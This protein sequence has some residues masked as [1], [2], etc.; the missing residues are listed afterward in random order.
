MIVLTAYYLLPCVVF[1]CPWF[2]TSNDALPELPRNNNGLAD[3]LFQALLAS[4]RIAVYRRYGDR[5][6]TLQHVSK[7]QVECSCA[8]LGFLFLQ[9]LGHI[10]SFKDRLTSPCGHV[11]RLSRD[12]H[13][14]SRLASCDCVMFLSLQSCQVI[15][16]EH[17]FR[18]N[19]SG[20]QPMMGGNAGSSFSRRQRRLGTG[21]QAALRQR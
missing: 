15:L 8:L 12:N 5:N 1:Y 4:T 14:Y 3:R 20:Q 18:H 16:I 6:F 21:Q 2:R 7:Q 11:R 10:T 19:E 13:S 9:S 17:I